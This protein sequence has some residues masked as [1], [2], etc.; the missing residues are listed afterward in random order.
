MNV[1]KSSDLV[2]GGFYFHI[3]AQSYC[4]GTLCIPHYSQTP[5]SFLFII[6]LRAQHSKDF[7]FAACLDKV[8]EKIR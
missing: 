4:I 5:T 3:Q 7:F 6:L 8:M 1:V 2:A